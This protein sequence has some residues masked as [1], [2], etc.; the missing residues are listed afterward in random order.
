MLE[1][2]LSSG[3]EQLYALKLYLITEIDIPE[4][5]VTKA[6][7]AAIEANWPDKNIKLGFY[8]EIVKTEDSVTS[9][10]RIKNVI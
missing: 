5:I 10:E 3:S 6:I 9:K 2:K 8:H 4:M 1:G 7:N